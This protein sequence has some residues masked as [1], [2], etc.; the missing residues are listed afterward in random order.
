MLSAGFDLLRIFV[1]LDLKGTGAS[2][3]ALKRGTGAL[4][5]ISRNQFS[6]KRWR[7]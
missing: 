1:P 6:N 5:D 3:L 2:N 4:Y 7:F